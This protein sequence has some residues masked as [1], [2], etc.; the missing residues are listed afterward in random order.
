MTAI[1]GLVHNFG[2]LLAARL[3]VGVG[4]AGGSP[5]S[6]SMISDY[7]PPSSRGCVIFLQH[8]HL[9]RRAVRLCRR[10]LD[11][12][13]FRL[14]QRLFVIGIPGILYALAVFWVVQGTEAWPVRRRRHAPKSERDHELP[15]RPTPTFWWISTSCAFTAFVSYGNGNF[16]PSFLMRNHGLSLAEWAPFSV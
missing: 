14:A 15:A 13:E 6:H 4:E 8:G 11:R 3:G 2:Q 1:S 10:R 16:M 9:H 7:F 5:P 12:P